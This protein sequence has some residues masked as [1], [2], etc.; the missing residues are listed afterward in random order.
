[1][2]EE[3]FSLFQRKNL[4]RESFSSPSS[5]RGISIILGLIFVIKLNS[6]TI[7]T[8]HQLLFLVTNSQN[9]SS[10]PFQV[11]VHG[12]F[13]GF[14]YQNFLSLPFPI[15]IIALFIFTVSRELLMALFSATVH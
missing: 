3:Y 5:P 12:T 10:L 7:H 15:T 13:P 4:E 14:V 11:T 9:C 2:R 8:N 6:I 1:M